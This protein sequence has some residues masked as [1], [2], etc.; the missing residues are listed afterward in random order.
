MY[1]HSQE[2]IEIVKSVI[3]RDESIQTNIVSAYNG[4]AR[5]GIVEEEEIRLL[6]AWLI[7]LETLS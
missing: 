1:L 3:S 6:E 4:L 5:A 2:A 7:D